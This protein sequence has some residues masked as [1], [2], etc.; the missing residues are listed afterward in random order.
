LAIRRAARC[1]ATAELTGVGANRVPLDIDLGA[2]VL[3]TGATWPSPGAPQQDEFRSLHST[4]R[5]TRA[6]RRDVIRRSST[7]GS[8]PRRE[9][10]CERLR[11]SNQRR[12]R[13]TSTT[14][15][16]DRGSAAEQPHRSGALR[17]PRLRNSLQRGLRAISVQRVALTTK[18]ICGH[19]V[20]PNLLYVSLPALIECQFRSHSLVG[21]ATLYESRI[22]QDAANFG[23]TS[24]KELVSWRSFQK[25]RVL[26]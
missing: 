15:R 1:R 23:L 2:A 5:S 7:C 9:L 24:C 25:R 19:G 16:P 12:W 10:R 13:G 21:G 17:V 20:L 11:R 18:T 6:E 4:R 3:S 22:M 8:G 14:G 26:S